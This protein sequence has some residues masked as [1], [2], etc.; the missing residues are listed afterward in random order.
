M[1]K[2]K[3]AGE[4]VGAFGMYMPDA[5]ISPYCIRLNG[6]FFCSHDTADLAD[7]V[8]AAFNQHDLEVLYYTIPTKE[9]TEE[10]DF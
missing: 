1:I 6:K 7:K 10:E 9:D 4:L 3:M 5:P 8:A 2:R